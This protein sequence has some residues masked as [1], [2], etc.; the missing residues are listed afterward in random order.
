MYSSA[1]RRKNAERLSPCLTELSYSS[2]AIT[3]LLVQPFSQTTAIVF[4]PAPAMYLTF[5][6]LVSIIQLKVSYCPYARAPICG[7][8]LG[9]YRP[10]H[11]RQG[12][13]E[14]KEAPRD[15]VQNV[16][17]K[18]QKTKNLQIKRFLKIQLIFAKMPQLYCKRQINTVQIKKN[19]VCTIE[20]FLMNKQY[21]SCSFVDGIYL[22]L[23]IFE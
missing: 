20:V 4:M 9:F 6:Y 10:G 3:D 22:T 21:I 11:G 1:A 18:T 15:G 17:L 13:R 19:R 7:L 14:M 12:E 16:K 23:T 5:I 2:V 8:Y